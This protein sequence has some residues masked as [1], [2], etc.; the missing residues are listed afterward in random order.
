MAHVLLS[1][2]LESPPLLSEKWVRRF[3]NRHDE[4]KSKY[5]RRYDYQRA[6]CED[7]KKILDWFRLFQNVKAKYGILEQDIYNFD[8]TGFLMGMTATYK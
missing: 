3:V 2:R 4:I 7:P 1:D 6:L 8:E 5:N